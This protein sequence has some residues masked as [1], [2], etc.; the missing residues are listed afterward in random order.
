MRKA[1]HPD[2]GA[3]RGMMANNT[4][5]FKGVYFHKRRKTYYA[6][7]RYEGKLHHLGY[8]ST[9]EEA[10]EAYCAGAKKLHG[11]FFNPGS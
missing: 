6:S 11:A 10:H 8:F 3:N 5:G 1:T 9:A 7:A 4:S 2:N